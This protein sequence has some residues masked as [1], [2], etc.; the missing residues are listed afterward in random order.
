VTHNAAPIRRVAFSHTPLKFLI[1]AAATALL[2][3]IISCS[4]AALGPNQHLTPAPFGGS[5]TAPARD[6]TRGATEPEEQAQAPPDLPGGRIAFS[7]QIDGN[8]E[9]FVMDSDGRS[10]VRLTDDSARDLEPEWSP[11]GTKIAFSSNRDA[12]FDIYIMDDEGQNLQRITNDPAQD[13]VPKWSPDGTRLAFFSTRLPTFLWVMDANGGNQRPVLQLATESPFCGGGGF[14]GGWSPDS[15]QVTFFIAKPVGSGETL[16]QICTVHIDGSRVK[17]QAND[18]PNFDV[19]SIWSHDGTQVA[20]RS[21]RDDDNS[22]VYIMA[23]DGSNQ[24]R[25]TSHPGT[26][27]EP[28]FSADDRWLVFHSSRNATDFELYVIR[29]DGTGLFRLTH[30]PANDNTPTWSPR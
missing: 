23:A 24:T 21:A 5:P 2:L 16:G 30:N 6:A 27:S 25:L 19:E 20:F 9:I 11:D 7:R 13:S 3:A 10:E 28:S 1:A 26:D 8:D 18:P 4:D 29:I 14:P 15:Q 17:V 22:E 12:N